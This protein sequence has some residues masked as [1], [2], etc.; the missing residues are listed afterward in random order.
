[1]LQLDTSPAFSD[2]NQGPERQVLQRM[3]KTCEE[4]ALEWG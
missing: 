1:M 2:P 3:Q 4:Q